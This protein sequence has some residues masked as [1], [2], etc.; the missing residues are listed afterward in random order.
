MKDPLRGTR[1][2]TRD[3]LIRAIGRL[4]RNI[5]KDGHTDGVWCIPNIWQKVINEGAT[6]LKVH[7]C[8]TPVNKALSEIS[9]CCHPFYATLAFER[10]LKLSSFH[11]LVIFL[12]QTPIPLCGCVL[13]T[14]HEY[15]PFVNVPHIS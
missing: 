13:E 12:I 8:C 2:K 14:D 3:E 1:Y 15:F 11:A 7:K 9:N 5:N 10:L 4:M 6:I